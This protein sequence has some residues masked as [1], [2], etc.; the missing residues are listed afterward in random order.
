[1]KDVAGHGRTILFVSHNMPAVTNL[2]GKCLYLDRGMVSSMGQT[3]EIV[4]KYLEK[5]IKLKSQSLRD[6]SDRSGSG[7]LRFT[8]TWIEYENGERA[9]I[10][11]SGENVKIVAEFEVVPGMD[12]ENCLFAFALYD[13]SGYQISDP[14]NFSNGQVNLGKLPQRGRVECLFPKIPLRSGKFVYNMIC[15]ESS[16]EI[17]DFLEE[18]GVFFVEPGDFFGTGRTIEENQGK[19]LFQQ[20]WSIRAA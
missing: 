7:H 13:E 5:N 8:D 14:G 20:S 15:R 17:L 2:C 11:L 1:M 6:R 18:A 9:N 16:W 19:I 10:V 3:P 4:K 12:L